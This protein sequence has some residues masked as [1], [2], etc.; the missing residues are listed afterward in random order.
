MYNMWYDI[1]EVLYDFGVEIIYI[2]KVKVVE[3]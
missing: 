2:I 1:I 3:S